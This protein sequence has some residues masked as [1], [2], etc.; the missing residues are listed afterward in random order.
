MRLTRSICY[1]VLWTISQYTG[2]E[3]S[4]STLGL[5]LDQ[6]RSYSKFVCPGGPWV[7]CNFA[8]LLGA[9]TARMGD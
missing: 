3:K 8:S 2:E 4:Y 1:R 5:S 9:A 6:N 7:Y